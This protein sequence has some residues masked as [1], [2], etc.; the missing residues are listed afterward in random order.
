LED[1]AINEEENIKYL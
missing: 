1:D